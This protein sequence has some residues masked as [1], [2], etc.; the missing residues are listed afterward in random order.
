M[1]IKL[2]KEDVPGG[3]GEGGYALVLWADVRCRS[4]NREIT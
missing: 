3:G 2:D 4:E 1:R